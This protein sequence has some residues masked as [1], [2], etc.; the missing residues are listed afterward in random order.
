MPRYVTNRGRITNLGRKDWLILEDHFTREQVD[1]LL[2][3]FSLRGH[4]HEIEDIA[5]L[6]DELAE[7]EEE[8]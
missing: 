5:G 1:A 8:D 2:E 6:D 3:V 4:S 7:L